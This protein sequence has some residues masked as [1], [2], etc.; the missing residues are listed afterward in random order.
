[1]KPTKARKE[2]RYEPLV[3]KKS[4]KPAPR[5]YEAPRPYGD[6]LS[7]K[8]DEYYRHRS[9]Y[10]SISSSSSSMSS[11]SSSRSSRYSSFSSSVSTPRSSSV[12]TVKSQSYRSSQATGGSPLSYISSDDLDYEYSDEN[13]FGRD[14]PQTYRRDYER[15]L[16]YPKSKPPTKKPRAHLQEELKT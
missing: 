10:D 3:D 1:M 6:P 11:S 8:L 15:D 13:L 16:D 7:R 9:F 4:K 12:S 2:P 5:S 14:Q